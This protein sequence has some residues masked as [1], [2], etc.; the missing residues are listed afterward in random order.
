MPTYVNFANYATTRAIEVH[1]LVFAPVSSMKITNYPTLPVPASSVCRCTYDSWGLIP[2]SKPFIA[3]PPVKENF[4]DI[5]GANGSIDATGIYGGE[6][7]GMREGTQ[8]FYVDH[9]PIENGAKL[10]FEELKRRITNFLH[11]N[12]LL[13]A[14][15]D[16]PYV[17]YEGRWMIDDM[18]TEESWSVITLK[19]ILDP[20]G[21]ESN[22]IGT[23]SHD[24]NQTL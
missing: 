11:G 22:V 17:F 12:R 23:L 4:V 3:L 13:V 14:L 1:S 24:Y 19:Y 9:Y 6:L 18:H 5:P 2:S 7:Y 21:K 16:D 10:S 15:V 20:Y 8:E